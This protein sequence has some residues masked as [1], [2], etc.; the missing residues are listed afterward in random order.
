MTNSKVELKILRQDE[1]SLKPY[2]EEFSVDYAPGMNV[3]SCLMA[4]QRNPVN[5]KGQTVHPVVWECNCLE[6]VCGACTMIINGQPRQSCTAL[7]D[8][9][10]QPIELRPLTKFPIIRDLMVNRKAMFDAFRQVKAWIP[11]DGTYDMG[12]G[13]KVSESDQEKAYAFSRCM[14]CGC[15]M[16]ACPQYNSHSAFIG[17]APISQAHLFNINPTGKMN[18]HERVH[19]LAGKGGVQDCGN[20]QNCVKVC[21]K[22][23]PITDAIAEMGRETTKQLLKDLLG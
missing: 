16:Q 2:W 11:I 3:I 15:C 4:I 19:A 6:E 1:P 23:I 5:K 8:N 7:I 17:P 14:V 20:A 18:K 10:K 12:P 13:Q 22:N 9:M 21:P